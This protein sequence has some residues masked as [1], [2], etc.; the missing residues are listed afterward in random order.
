MLLHDQ[1]EVVL[2]QVSMFGWEAAVIL[3]VL[4]AVYIG[5]RWWRRR[6]AL[7]L[8]IPRI[9]VPELRA[10]IEAGEPI[11]LI[12]VRGRDATELDQRRIPG[13]SI[14][15]LDEIEAG[16]FTGAL[17]GRSSFTARVRTKLLPRRQ[18]GCCTGTAIC[19]RDRCA[20]GS[21]RGSRPSGLSRA[22]HRHK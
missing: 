1:I 8:G 10:L 15:H 4:L 22:A 20:A 19:A 16:K 7:A 9:D 3:T 12:D 14:M 17:I 5:W 2:H 18:S 6:M 11:E 21:T 13:A